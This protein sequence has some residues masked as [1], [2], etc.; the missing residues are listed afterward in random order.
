MNVSYYLHFATIV[1]DNELDDKHFAVNIGTI[2]PE[3]FSAR[4][5]LFELSYSTDEGWRLDVFWIN[6]FEIGGAV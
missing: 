4:K 1:I 2:V 3:V 6:V 5:S